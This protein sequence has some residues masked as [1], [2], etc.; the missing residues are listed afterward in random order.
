M[1]VVVNRKIRMLAFDR[2]CAPKLVS[3]TLQPGFGL[4]L[5][6]GVAPFLEPVGSPKSAQRRGLFQPADT[7]PAVRPCCFIAKE[8]LLFQSARRPNQDD[9]GTR[10]WPH[11]AHELFDV[12]MPVRGVDEHQVIEARPDENVAQKLLPLR[13][14]RGSRSADRLALNRLIA[15]ER[16]TETP[17]VSAPRTDEFFRSLSDE[18]AL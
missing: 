11:C 10:I 6:N 4:P 17:W 15:E 9:A 3:Q 13:H 14:E 2:P 12:F 18:M 16:L 7:D 1:R 5:L 8:R